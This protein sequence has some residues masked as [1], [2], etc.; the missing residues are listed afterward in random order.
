MQF[1]LRP[2]YLVLNPIVSVE[3]I[4]YPPVIELFGKVGVFTCFKTEGS[5][6]RLKSEVNK[7]KLGLCV[8]NCVAIN[9]YH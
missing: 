3:L 1:C 9:S 4:Q 8:S 7:S 2:L 5:R 6:R